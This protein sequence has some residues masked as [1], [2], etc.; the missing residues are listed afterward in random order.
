[1]KNPV[2]RLLVVALLFVASA[3]GQ[4]S[5]TL[6]GGEVIMSEEEIVASEGTGVAP[7]DLGEFKD[8]D[9]SAS[10]KNQVLSKYAH[11]DPNR[12]VPTGLLE[13]AVT[14]FEAN[15]SLFANQ[16]YLSVIDF[17]KKSTKVR[18]FVVNLQ[19][20]E[21]WAMRTAHG[22]GS[23]SNNDGIAESFGNVLNSGKS[24][25]GFY[26]TAETYMGRNGNSLRLDG[27]SSTNSRARSRAV[28]IH[29]ANY[30]SEVDKIQGLS[31]GCPA[32][33]HAFRDKLIGQIKE[34]SLIYA[35]LSG[36]R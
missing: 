30:V 31:L 36:I 17:S 10:E 19:S 20:G 34:G 28:V 21:V 24:S 3:C 26:R 5:S 18:F 16:E 32:I 25:L 1:M 9:F 6:T 15:K 12:I 8:V 4:N 2:P 23:D 27:L 13:K 35:G 33:T 11:L 22:K 14:Y 29:G 7:A